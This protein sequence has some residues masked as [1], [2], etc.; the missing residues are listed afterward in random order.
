[1]LKPPKLGG[2]DQLGHLVNDLGFERSCEIVDCHPATLRKWLRGAAPVPAAAMQAL[3]WLTSFG[4]SDAC[5]EAHWSHQWAMGRI[6][7]LEALLGVNPR[8]G[9]ASNDAQPL[10]PPSDAQMPLRQGTRRR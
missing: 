9:Q 6:R 2:A 3:Y 4:Y 5:S 10:A 1:M 8:L 7:E